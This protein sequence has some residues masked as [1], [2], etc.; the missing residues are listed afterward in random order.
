[1][2]SVLGSADDDRLTYADSLRMISAGVIENPDTARYRLT[3]PT[4]T[5]TSTTTSKST[6]KSKKK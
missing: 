2:Q 4:T 6:S 3:I 1:M 5:T